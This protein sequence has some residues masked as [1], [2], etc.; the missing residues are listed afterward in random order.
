[1][2]KAWFGFPNQACFLPPKNYIS[3]FSKSFFL[4]ISF[5]SVFSLIIEDRIKIVFSISSLLI[6]LLVEGLKTFFIGYLIKIEDSLNIKSIGIFVSF[7]K[8]KIISKIS[9][10]KNYI[11][12]IFQILQ[13]LKLLYFQI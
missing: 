9:E 8:P 10:V 6:G 12:N 2:K 5:K 4:R 13:N 3:Y 7:L 11:Q 1:M